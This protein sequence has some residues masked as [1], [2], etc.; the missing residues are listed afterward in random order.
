M[1]VKHRSIIK[2]SAEKKSEKEVSSDSSFND[3][4]SDEKN[5]NLLEDLFNENMKALEINHEEE[6]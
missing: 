2:R 6:K 4:A 5:D 3:R 1:L